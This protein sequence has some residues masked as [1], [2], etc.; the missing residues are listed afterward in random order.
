MAQTRW[1]SH[2]MTCVD[3]VLVHLSNKT[4]TCTALSFSYPYN[5]KHRHSFYH[6]Y[7]HDHKHTHVTVRRLSLCSLIICHNPPLWPPLRGQMT[8]QQGSYWCVHCVCVN[9]P[10]E[11]IK[12]GC[13]VHCVRNS[14][15]VGAA[16]CWQVPRRYRGSEIWFFLAFGSEHKVDVG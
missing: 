10:R 15:T 13:L 4:H 12:Y 9:Q 3:Q 1:G 11:L 2:S 14:S 7:A 16:T 8:S 5:H 6:S